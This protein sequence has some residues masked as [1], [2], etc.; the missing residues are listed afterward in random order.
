MKH[1]VFIYKYIERK[2]KNTIV[3]SENSH[4]NAQSAAQTHICLRPLWMLMLK[5]EDRAAA[6]SHRSMAIKLK[7][8]QKNPK[9][10]FLTSTGVICTKS[11]RL[12]EIS[13]FV[14]DKR[15]FRNAVNIMMHFN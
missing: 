6:Q 1:W 8:E 13:L 15:L 3:I 10:F 4:S 9:D 11:T 2:K 5:K 12:V 14:V 7:D